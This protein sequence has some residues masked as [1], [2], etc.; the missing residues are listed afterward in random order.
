M[1]SAMILVLE[2][3]NLEKNRQGPILSIIYTARTNSNRDGYR[4][5][6]GHETRISARKKAAL[7]N[8]NPRTRRFELP[9]H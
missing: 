2:G 6:L 1:P 5:A 8:S 9:I 4:M 7:T 3:E